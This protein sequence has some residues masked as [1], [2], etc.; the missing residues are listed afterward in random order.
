MTDMTLETVIPGFLVRAVGL[1]ALLVCPAINAVEEQAVGPRWQLR[2]GDSFAMKFVAVAFVVDGDDFLLGSDEKIGVIFQRSALH[3]RHVARF[4]ILH[5][6]REIVRR[7]TF[8]HFES[9]A[10]RC[11]VMRF[12]TNLVEAEVLAALARE[13]MALPE[14]DS[15]SFVSWTFPDRPLTR[16]FELILKAGHLKGAD[17]WHL[18]CALYLSPT[19]GELSFLSLDLRQKRVAAKLGFP[20]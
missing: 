13:G 17:L 3:S 16:E 10:P 2:H 6:P 19:P 4:A 1:P 8:V 12:V 5:Q 9:A 14:S 18:A 11:L 20:V 7:F 15:L